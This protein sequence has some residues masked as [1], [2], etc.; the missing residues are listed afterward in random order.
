M[1]VLLVRVTLVCRSDDPIFK[2]YN[3]CAL[4]TVVYCVPLYML[5]NVPFLAP[6]ELAVLLSAEALVLVSKAS[7]GGWRS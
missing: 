1:G 3:L 7:G 4:A 2:A 5:S 6:A